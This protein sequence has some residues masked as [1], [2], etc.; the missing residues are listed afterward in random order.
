MASQQNV[1]FE[2]VAELVEQLS[3]EQQELLLRQIQSRIHQNGKSVEE[4][5]KLFRSAQIDAQVNQEPS[6]RREEWYKEIVK[7]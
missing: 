1:P 6:P 5:S 3:V 7:I 2:T 4:K